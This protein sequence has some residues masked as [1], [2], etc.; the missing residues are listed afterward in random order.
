MFLI[1]KLDAFI[2]SQI[3]AMSNQKIINRVSLII[4]TITAFKVT[5]QWL[6]LLPEL[7]M[8]SSGKSYYSNRTG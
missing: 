4:L 2:S 5:L 6:S 8:F 7:T 3:F 1:F